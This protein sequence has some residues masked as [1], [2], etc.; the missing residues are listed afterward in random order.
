MVGGVD[1]ADWLVRGGLALDW[2]RYSRGGY[3]AA[4][5]EARRADKGMW[6]GSFVKPWDYRP[7]TKAGGRVEHCSDEAF[8]R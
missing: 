8:A 2:P 1:L 4:Q 3:V 6:A 5:A 7:C